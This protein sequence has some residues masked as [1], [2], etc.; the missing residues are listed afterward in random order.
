MRVRY[1][2]SLLHSIKEWHQDFQINGVLPKGYIER[3]F[4]N[5]Y[6][7]KKIE[8]EAFQNLQK[9]G[10]FNSKKFSRILDIGSGIGK[11]ISVCNEK[12][13]YSIGL[14]PS[15]NACKLART[16]LKEEGY[17]RE[18]LV[19]GKAE[20]LPFPETTSSQLV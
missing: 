15:H 6:F 8:Y 13:Y 11:F 1:S 17:N 19:C 10:I 5:I 3:N 14:E 20:E 16:F 18:S 12:G 9:K 2:E 7:D 4:Q